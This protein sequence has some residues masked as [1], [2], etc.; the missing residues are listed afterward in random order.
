[1]AAAVAIGLLSLPATGAAGG[2][3]AM[4]EGTPG[5][6][7]SPDDHPRLDRRLVA[8][9][10]DDGR[11]GTGRMGDVYGYDP[12]TDVVTVELLAATGKGPLVEQRVRRLGAA[13][14]R[15]F[16]DALAFRLPVS[17]LGSLGLDESIAWVSPAAVPIPEGTG[18]GVAEIGA[19][20]WHAAGFTGG[21]ISIAVIDL[22][23]DGYEALLGTELPSSVGIF[24]ACGGDMGGLEDHGTAVAEIVHEVAPHAALHLMCIETTLDLAAAVDE[25]ITRGATVISHSVGWLNTGRGDGTGP[26]TGAIIQSARDNGILWV[27]S[28]GNYAEKHWGGTFTD[29]GLSGWH[30]FAAGPDETIEFDMPAGRSVIV[31]LKWDDWPASSNDY[32]LYLLEEDGDGI[33]YPTDV[34]A[35]SENLQT[36]PQPPAESLGYTNPGPGTRTYHLAVL[37]QSAVAT[38]LMDLFVFVPNGAS[39]PIDHAVAARS[40]ND[41]AGSPI[42]LAA[43]AFYWDDGLVE[44]F[45]SRGPNIDGVAKPDLAAPDG[46]AGTTYSSFFGT[47][48]AAPHTAGAAALIQQATQVCAA[49]SLHA[50]VL[51]HTDPVGAPVPND[52]YGH[53]RLLLGSAPAPGDPVVRYSG[54]NRYAT[55][56]AASAEDFPCGAETVFIA[57][58]EN[59]PDA[60]AGAAVARRFDAPILLVRTDS[61]P[62]ETAAELAR[63]LPTEIVILGGET[64]VS[65]GV[66]AALAAYGAVTRAAGPNRYATAAAISELAYPDPGSVAD[67][68]VASGA[69]FA[70]ALAGGPAAAFLGGPMLLTA[71][72]ALPTETRDEILRLGP[73]RIWVLGGSGVVSAGVFDELADLGIPTARVAGVNRYETAVAASELGFPG[74][75]LES[76]PAV[77]HRVYIA[78]AT[79]FPDALAGGALAGKH[80]GPVLLVAADNIPPVVEAEIARLGP[81]EIVILG[82]TGA[83]SEAVESQLEDLIGA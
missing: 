57:T 29:P 28:A 80:T 45:S 82:G 74:S 54:A 78:V 14:L 41:L 13:D 46:V 51:A 67:L 68:F 21:G 3:G 20:A 48:A 16:G 44:S 58:G 73:T 8:L 1:M 19:D 39:L 35:A 12:L 7:D 47:S 22:G 65:P 55:A 79:N 43:G 64:V 27:N 59:F 60:L 11:R 42:V 40:L 30:D 25:A 83:V 77:V 4:I 49:A 61:V 52:D 81:I 6:L 23:F 10:R 72:N 5:S 38:P 31:Y 62:D 50:I 69:V 75:T 36:G 33:D 71:P 76:A 56:A 66:E 53:G 70:D 9:S 32:N 2:S 63:L 34:V 17:R 26:F 24:D 18:E 15:R 37:R